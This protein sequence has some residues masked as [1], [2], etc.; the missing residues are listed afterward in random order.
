MLWLDKCVV[1]DSLR[2]EDT[3]LLLSLQDF[4]SGVLS[5]DA[6]L[7]ASTKLQSLY[8]DVARVLH[9]S[10]QSRGGDV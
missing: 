1:R 6:C 5:S 9:G 2:E 3:C 7:S 4:Q 8:K 10:K